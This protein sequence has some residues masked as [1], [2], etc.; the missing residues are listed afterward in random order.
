MGL[1]CAGAH[2]FTGGSP[3]GK[4]VLTRSL[5][6]IGYELAEP[7]EGHTVD[8]V[9]IVNTSW[10][11]L[12]D[13]T[14]PDAATLHLQNIARSISINTKRPV[15]IV[16]AYDSDDFGYMMFNQSRTTDA[17]STNESFIPLNGSR[18]SYKQRAERWNRLLG[19]TVDS[20]D[21]KSV[22]EYS[23]TFADNQLAT[24]CQLLGVPL[25][26]AAMHSRDLRDAKF[27][28][29]RKFPS[30]PET[31]IKQL[32][33]GEPN[34][35]LLDSLVDQHVNI[36]FL[37]QANVTAL[38]A[39]IVELSGTA[40]AQN[41]YDIAD[42]G[43]SWYPEK[44]QLTREDHRKD[45]GRQA[46]RT[47]ATFRIEFPTLDPE[48]FRLVPETI[49]NVLLWVKLNSITVGSGDLHCRLVPDTKSPGMLELL[50]AF[51]AQVE[52]R[53]SWVPVGSGDDDFEQQAIRML[54]Q[55]R[56]LAGVSILED[57]VESF[58]LL[59]QQIGRW[60]AGRRWSNQC[61]VIA[62]YEGQLT[63]ESLR[64]PKRKVTVGIVELANA[65]KWQALFS[66]PE[67][68]QSLF[69]HLESV[70]GQCLSGITLQRSFEDEDPHFAGT[71]QLGFWV[72]TR[73]CNLGENLIGREHAE[74]V[75]VID[76][77]FEALSGIQAWISCWNWVP[78]F[79]HGEDRFNTPY[80]DSV[81]IT[82][83]KDRPMDFSDAEWCRNNLRGLG[84]CIW[85]CESLFSRIDHDRAAQ[86]AEMTSIG[87]AG[88]RVQSIS[89]VAV[90]QMEK[91][92]MP[93]LPCRHGVNQ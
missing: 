61:R 43:A 27:T 92:L 4:E 40:I 68:L 32:Y 41:L 54:N 77:H 42:S 70:D 25:H 50:P 2:L 6:S 87:D 38:S 9:V 59:K 29:Y 83:I 7:S 74:I 24:F 84:S 75:Q 23:G 12:Y 53:A 21:V 51:N 79:D 73:A 33:Y 63:G 15:V 89:G 20:A 30:L 76:K 62:R 34:T 78:C 44:K 22:I 35:K 36:A 80:E 10:V 56:I 65:R 39:P 86:V 58:D 52:P 66:Q 14:N 81:S 71:T 93:I 49:L 82:R 57:R 85:L 69:V 37:L 31:A 88:Y 48:R 28:A 1:T 8:I 19:T 64:T 72:N 67:E 18:T 55:P 13:L 46:G 90:D 26:Q 60:L 5:N 16:A 17:F 11:S 47:P 91:V 45:A 3:G